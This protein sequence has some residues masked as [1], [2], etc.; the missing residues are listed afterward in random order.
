LGA[1]GTAAFVLGYLGFRDHLRA[2]GAAADAWDVL[3]RVLQLF[4]LESGALADGASV[5]AT[6]QVARFLAPAVGAATLLKVLAAVFR[7]QAQRLRVRLF[8]DHVVVCGLDEKGLALVRSLRDQDRRV[9]AVE[10]D[11]E[12][13]NI[14]SGRAAGVPVIVGDATDPE[15]LRDAGVTRAGW[16]VIVCGG[17]GA[18][19]TVAASVQRLASRRDRPLDCLAHIDDPRLCEL[20]QTRYLGARS[21]GRFRLD[22]FN[23]YERGAR[24][25]LYRH[26]F[27]P[28]GDRPAEAGR[29]APH[30]LVVGLGRLGRSLIVQAVRDWRAAG[31]R[32]QLAVTVVD[33]EAGARIRSLTLG[34]P[35]LTATCTFEPVEID[36]T[37]SAFDTGAFLPR[38]DAAPPTVAYVCVDDDLLAL[39]AGLALHRQLHRDHVPVVVRSRTGRGLSS[40]LRT[41]QDAQAFA[42]LH[43]FALLEHTCDADLLLG[44]TYERVARALHEIYVRRRQTDGWRWGPELDR[45]RRTDPALAPWRELPEGLRESNRSQAAHIGVK[46]A[47]VGC[48]L[49]EDVEGTTPTFTFADH[50]VERLAEMEHARWVEERRATGWRSGTRDPQRRRTPY[51]VPYGAL[52]EDVKEYDRIFVRDLPRVL[53]QFGYRIVRV[54]TPAAPPTNGRAAAPGRAG[55]RP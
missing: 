52:S 20:L 12:N 9:V 37:S 30:V 45:D 46:L 5:P 27:L 11:A 39:R 6:L 38:G 40:L 21:D 7:E 26:P 44:G 50:E 18:N 19:A 33:V 22:F 49:E 13:D 31:A 3:Y 2:A 41:R 36:I 48:A 28:D 53:S 47:A 15:V 29:A 23:T 34:H 14:A 25:L 17:S 16:V 1:L 4:T 10:R 51:L 32:G 24:I 54:D 42:D 43:A 55:A 35:D 8:R